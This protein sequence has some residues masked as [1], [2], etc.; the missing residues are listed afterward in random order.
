MDKI[1]KIE[2]KDA[3]DIFLYAI[4]TCIWCKKT[5]ELLDKCKVCYRYI[6]VDL[7]IGKEQDKIKKKLRKYNPSCSYPTLVINKKE[8]IIGFNEEKILKLAGK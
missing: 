3:G 1:I 6:Y 7:L 5:R 2:G 8:C 4:S